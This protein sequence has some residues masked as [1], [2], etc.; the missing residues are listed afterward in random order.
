MSTYTYRLLLAYDGTNYA[1]W[2]VQPHAK[3]LAGTIEKAVN[4]IFDTPCALLGA[5][6]TD[7]GVHALGQVAR[8]TIERELDEVLLFRAL[9]N[10]LPSDI[11]L[12][13][14]IRDEEF[15]PH[16]N[17]EKKIYYYHLFLARPL[18]FVA[19]YGWYPDKYIKNFDSNVFETAMKCFVGTHDFSSFVRLAPGK[20]PVRA[21]DEISVSRMARFNALQVRIVG[22]GFLHFQ[23]RRMIGAAC[24]VASRDDSTLEYLSELLASPS[25]SSVALGKAEARGLCLRSI[26][27]KDV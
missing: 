9:R 5:S 23:I 2:Q 13:S 10:A 17:V 8:L 3:T 4:A 18:P 14:A 1:G 24:T 15:H 16:R 7:S 25:D 12:R 19:R 6:R 22:S 11:L 21:V 20:D 26:V 27:Y